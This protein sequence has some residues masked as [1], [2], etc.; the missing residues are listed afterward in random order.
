VGT[1]YKTEV[2][3]PNPYSII[4]DTFYPVVEKALSL[5]DYLRNYNSVVSRNKGATKMKTLSSPQ[6]WSIEALKTTLND[7]DVK[8][9]HSNWTAHILQEELQN[10]CRALFACSQWQGSDFTQK[11]TGIRIEFKDGFNQTVSRIWNNVVVPCLNGQ[12]EEW[13][14]EMMPK[15]KAVGY[16]FRTF[17][18]THMMLTD[19]QWEQQRSF[20]LP[21]WERKL[22]SDRFVACFEPIPK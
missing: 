10:M 7:L 21:D 18:C 2:F 11:Y 14:K 13:L 16:Q 8:S 3:R 1:Q 12:C 9:G 15:Y 6:R 22:G 20:C 19:K 4:R 17:V 5:D